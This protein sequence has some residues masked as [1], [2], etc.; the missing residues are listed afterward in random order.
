[1]SIDLR[2]HKAAYADMLRLSTTAEGLLEK[3]GLTRSLGE[4]VK[5]RVSQINGCAFCLRM[6]T[7]VAIEL[8]ETP[9]RLAVLPAWWESQYFTETEKAALAIA[10]RV[11]DIANRDPQAYDESALT[12]EQASAVAWLALVMNAWNRLAVTSHYPVGPQD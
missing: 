4:L 8:G 6:H 12:P 9:D 5:L 3:T 10:E 7:R 1:M 2:S 11:T